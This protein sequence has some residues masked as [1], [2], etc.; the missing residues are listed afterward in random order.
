[1]PVPPRR[2]RHSSLV[3][4][5]WLLPLVVC[6]LTAAQDKPLPLPA[7]S[8]WRA[9]SSTTDT[10]AMASALAIDGD[11]T[12]RWGGA[13]AAQ[14]WLQVDLGE[15]ADVAG[16]LLHW[17]SGFAASYRI[18]S[19]V[20]GQEWETDFETTD[21]QGGIDYI[22]FP[23]TRARYLRLASM[24]LSSDWGVSVLELE[25][26]SASE[27][28]LI[29][30]LSEGTDPATVWGGSA[31]PPRALAPKTRTLNIK[32]Q[33]PLPTTGLQVFWGAARQRS[34]LEGREEKGG[35]RVLASDVAPQGDTSLLAARKPI[36]ASE[37]R[38]TVTPAPR[39]APMIRRLRLLPP[40]RTMTPLRRYEVVAAR[41]HR[42]LFPFNL[43]N[44]QVYWTMVGIPA[45]MQKSLFDEWGNL[46][47]FKGGPLVQPLWRDSER[48]VH[49]AMGSNLAHSLRDGWMPMPAVQWSPGPNLLMRS[50]SFGVE[51]NG[52]PITLLRHRI[53][54]TSQKKVEGELIMLV[55][56][57]Q[58]NPSW[59]S[60]GLSPIDEVAIEGPVT[61][62]AVRVNGR[63]LMR[64]LTPVHARGASGFGAH[65]EDELTLSVVYGA[66]PTALKAK[67]FD[68]LAAAYLSYQVKLAPGEKREVVLAF[69]LGKQRS[70]PVTHKLPEAPAIDRAA[71]MGSSETAGEAFDVLAERVAEQWQ[72][73]VTRVGFSLP[74]RSLV[75]MLRAQLAYMMI[76]QTGPAIQPGPRNYSRSFVR[77]GAATSTILMRMGLANVARDYLRW[78]TDHALRDNGLVSP[79][80]N[81]DGSVNK[82]W[83]SDL[84]FD[85][86]GEYVAFVADVAR[87][88][89]GPQTVREYL[90]KVRLALKFLQQLRERTLVPGY[91]ADRE[92]PERFRGI[93]A[94]SISHEGYPTPT[95]SYWDNYYSL[96]GWHDGAWLAAALGNAEMDT[97][98]RSQYAVLRE[99][100]AA[101][102]RETMAWKEATWIPSSADMGENDPTS[103]SIGIDPCGQI[104]L[105]PDTALKNTYDMYIEDVRKRS[106]PGSL[107]AYTPYEIRNILTYVHMNRPAEAHELLDTFMRY[108]RPLPWQVMAEVVHS[109]LRH[110]IYMGDMPHTWNGTEYVRAVLGMLMHEADDHLALLPGAPPAWLLGDGASLTD[111]RTQY[112]R[113]TMTAR[114]EGSQL[115]LEL[116]PGLLPAIPVFVNWPSRTRPKQVTVDGETRTEHTEQGI[117]VERPFTE[118]VAQW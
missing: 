84:E 39:V 26:L 18:L 108:R 54:N 29:T 40:D 43:R 85:S 89:G 56:P 74:E 62:T 5:S 95:H 79:I 51:Q 9:S 19:S 14:H 24:P 31:T 50:E 1:M 118:L 104:D 11:A 83:G 35:F 72:E 20:D 12:T 21:G 23:P 16:V 6:T 112:G 69:P 58:I 73:R 92:A 110:P 49:A 61:D 64:S 32:L 52:Q 59:Q 38:L 103:T 57:T 93:I 66:L 98:A 107:W 82:G 34:Q 8:Q 106:V 10:P 68:G 77:D 22:F 87:L 27:A 97:W 114:Q 48:R 17:D 86:Q 116:G 91:Q 76:N 71:L 47:P 94:P 53:Q 4:F 36:V 88:D 2:A 33:R 67:D 15:V 45:G 96:K 109:R 41:V 3:L 113:L 102:I 60:G 28:P 90:P 42:E 46:E 7:R 65:G 80:L 117:R 13:F 44:Q 75:D 111:L 78:Y 55:R 37:L 99:S 63:L 25:P 101:S 81:D 70:D 30:G 105:L 100:V 115:R